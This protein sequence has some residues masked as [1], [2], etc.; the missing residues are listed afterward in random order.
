[1][2][3]AQVEQSTRQ[4]SPTQVNSHHKWLNYISLRLTNPVNEELLESLIDEVCRSEKGSNQRR[5]ALNRLLRVIPLLNG[6]Y[7]SSHQDYPE[8]YNRTLEWLCK[9][10]DRYQRRS[11]TPIEQSFVTWINGYLKW[12]VRDLY[13]PEDKYNALRVYLNNPDEESS[14]DPLENYPDPKFSLTLLDQKIAQLQ[15]VEQ[16]HQ[17]KII[18]SYIER[19]PEGKLTQ[20]HPRQYPQ[21]HCQILALRLLLKDPP[22]SIADLARDF[23]INNQTLYSHWKQKCLPLLQEIARRFGSQP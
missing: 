9:N 20:C 22:E 5:K 17:G 2:L 23:G 7:R 4:D 10:I 8:A 1:M 21:C 19:D 11:S 6:L 15:E 12:R 16:R 18:R 14:Q 13:A 3:F